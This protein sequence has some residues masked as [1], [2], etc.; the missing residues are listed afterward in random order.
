[1]NEQ[2]KVDKAKMKK[3]QKAEL[4]AKIKDLKRLKRRL[5]LL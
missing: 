1:L 2:L 5:K 4:L 3:K